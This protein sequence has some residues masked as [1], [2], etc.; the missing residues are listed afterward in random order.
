MG[1][2]K[3]EITE[4]LEAAHRM[5]RTEGSVRLGDALTDEQCLKYLSDAELSDMPVD[6]LV[7]QEMHAGVMRSKKV[8][9]KLTKYYKRH[10]QKSKF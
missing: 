4:Q 3:N 1:K 6:P 10:G 8:L 5:G 2:I 9:N 7:A